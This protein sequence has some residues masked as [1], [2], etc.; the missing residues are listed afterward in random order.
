MNHHSRTPWL[1]SCS[2]NEIKSN[3]NPDPAT[4]LS[5]K[6]EVQLS[7][8][9][10]ASADFSNN[11]P[12]RQDFARLLLLQALLKLE[13]V[14][15]NL[16][17][18][19]MSHNTQRIQKNKR[20][21]FLFL[22]LFA[23]PRM[24]KHHVAPVLRIRCKKVHVAVIVGCQ[25]IYF[26]LPCAEQIVQTHTNQQAGKGCICGS[27]RHSCHHSRISLNMFEPFCFAVS[28][29]VKS[30]SVGLDSGLAQAR[31]MSSHL[32]PAFTEM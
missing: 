10:V 8:L 1:R 31:N 9:F 17:V 11:M 12:C 4:Q 25:R 29:A 19:T 2:T 20:C 22:F 16:Q 6:C 15:H 3:T 13:T 28:P 30:L 21:L 18:L 24:R 32:L 27:P 5:N 26:R 23:R 14:K 7:C